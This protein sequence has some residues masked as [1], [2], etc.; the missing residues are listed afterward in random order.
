AVRWV[1]DRGMVFYGVAGRPDRLVAGCA[2][3]TENKHADARVAFLGEIARSITSSLDFDTVLRRIVEG[4][5]ALC[6]SDS[7]AVFLR[8]P[9]SSAMVPNHRVGPWWRAFETLRITPGRGVG[10]TVMVTGQPLR[11]DDYRGDPRVPPD[12]RGADT[13]RARDIIGRQ[14]QHLARLVDD[15]LDVSRV[16]AGK[17][18]LGLQAL[19]LAETA[20]RVAALYG[21]PRGGRHVIRVEA[22]P[23]WVSADPT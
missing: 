2:D 18:V 12:S 15:L 9:E 11:T 21:G 5:Q 10:G 23:V 22:T 20:H 16:V 13:A 6:G 19:E 8:D 7:A 4:A 14:V 1:E 17:V 3:V